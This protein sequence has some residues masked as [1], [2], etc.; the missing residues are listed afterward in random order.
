[1]P[2][3]NYSAS[4]TGAGSS[5]AKSI[6]RTSDGADAREVTLP[7]GKAGTL[8]TRTDNDTGTVTMSSGGHG[9]TTGMK[10]D[11]YWSGGVRYGVTVGSVSGTSVPIDLGAGTNLPSTSTAVVVTPQVTINATVDGDALTA[12]GVCAEY[13]SPTSTAKAHVDFQDNG[14][15]SVVQL[16]LTA[17]VPRIYDITGGATNIFTGN[18]IYTVLASN[19]SS[20]EAAT[21]KLIWGSDT[22]P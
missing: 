19:G 14:P 17:N 8:T 11:V 18:V 15:A 1:M 4:L 21:L 2:T 3:L 5:I 22:T 9:I 7:V 12:L 16:D 10:V 13:A 6:P 20:A